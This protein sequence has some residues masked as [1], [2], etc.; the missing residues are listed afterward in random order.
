MA[1]SSRGN[2]WGVWERLPPWA[3]GVAATRESAACASPEFSGARLLTRP[4]PPEFNGVQHLQ[5]PC[6]A[7]LFWRGAAAKRHQGTHTAAAL[8]QSKS[9]ERG[10][11]QAP[12]RAWLLTPSP[13]SSAGARRLQTPSSADWLLRAVAAKS[14]WGACSVGTPAAVRC[15]TLPE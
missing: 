8:D 13:L 1:G 11:L 15:R 6:F 12:C 4:P 3:L 14:H 2:V 7:D 10:H 5:M 9:V